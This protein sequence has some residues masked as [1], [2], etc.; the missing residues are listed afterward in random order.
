[1]EHEV[2]LLCSQQLASCH[3]SEPEKSSP[4]PPNRFEIHV[5]NTIPSTQGLPDA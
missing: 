1:M 3:S 4:R 2:S 5:N